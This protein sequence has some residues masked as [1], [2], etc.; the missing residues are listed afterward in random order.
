MEDLKQKIDSLEALLRQAMAEL[1]AINESLSETACLSRE[2]VEVVEDTEMV[3][4]VVEAVEELEAIDKEEYDESVVE[5]IAQ[6][7]V[8]EDDA[9]EIILSEASQTEAP[10]RPIILGNQFEK[11]FAQKQKPSYGDVV[12]KSMS[13]NDRFRYQRELFHGSAVEMNETMAIIDNLSSL[14]EVQDYLSSMSW[15]EESETVQN[16]Y[17]ML[18]Q[19]FS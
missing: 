4:E 9:E 16:F 15:D 6:E 12:S 7:P 13:L 2:E 3:E 8:S 14:E 17:A 19:H 5:D 1:A 18:E 11:T 10:S